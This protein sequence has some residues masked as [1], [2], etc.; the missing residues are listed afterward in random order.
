MTDRKAAFDTIFDIV[1]STV[2]QP[3]VPVVSG[4]EN[5]VANAVA[6]EIAPVIVNATNSEP[7]YQSRILRGIA[8]SAIGYAAGKLGY[9]VSNEDAQTVIEI[10]TQIVQGAGLLYATYGRIVGASKKP[11]GQ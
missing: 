8:I 10:I 11:L 5:A 4:A 1:R 7:W 9:A 6:K 3:S 2:A